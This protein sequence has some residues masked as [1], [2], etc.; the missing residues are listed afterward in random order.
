[1]AEPLDPV[2][3]VAA[4]LAALKRGGSS[5][6][7]ADMASRYGVVGPTASTA[8]GTP[9]G[10]VRLLAKR[11]GRDHDLA[12]A[13]WATGQYEARMLACFVDEPARVTVAQ[14]DRWC[15]D[16]DNWAVC[17]TA[18]FHLFDRV[19]HAYGRA[20][21]WSRR[22][23]EFVRRG[24]FAL[25]ASLALHDK[26]ADDHALAGFLPL[27]EAGARDERNFVKKGVSWALRGIG[28]RRPGLRGACRALADRLARSDDPSSRWV[29]RDALRDLNRP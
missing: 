16:F 23:A 12:A 10:H 3:Q 27:I 21:A 11:L 8:F 9:M 19:P 17:D 6:V 26:H 15:R 13:L 4:A 5:K 1:M 29:G 25:M 20:A 22:K 14:M 18:C 7:R 28:R 2:P 24:G